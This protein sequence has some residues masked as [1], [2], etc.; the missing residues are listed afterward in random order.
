M[1]LHLHFLARY[2]FERNMGRIS[3]LSFLFHI[4]KLTP[5][6]VSNLFVPEQYNMETV[7]TFIHEHKP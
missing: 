3:G 7:I 6:S 4:Q 1:P 2:T 5:P